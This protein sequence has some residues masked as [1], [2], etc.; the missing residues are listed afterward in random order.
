MVGAVYA[1]ESQTMTHLRVSGFERFP[2]KFLEDLQSV[3]QLEVA[4]PI[5]VWH[6]NNSK[7]EKINRTKSISVRR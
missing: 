2:G 5:V 4:L 6:T 3:K 7:S 1:L